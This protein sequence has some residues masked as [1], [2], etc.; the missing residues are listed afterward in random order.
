MTVSSRAHKA[1]SQKIS[2]AEIQRI[3]RIWIHEVQKML[4]MG[5]KYGTPLPLPLNKD[6][7]EQLEAMAAK[8]GLPWDLFRRWLGVLI[9]VDSLAKNGPEGIP[10]V[11]QKA[12][13]LGIPLAPFKEYLFAEVSDIRSQ[14]DIDLD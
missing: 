2:L 7:S 12:A 4:F 11:A 10:S 9:Y 6:C 13:E 3:N 8:W 5:A 14:L 1:L